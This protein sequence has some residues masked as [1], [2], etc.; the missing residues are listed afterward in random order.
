[1]HLDKI[2]LSKEEL[3]KL[4]NIS[5]YELNIL[6]IG[7]TKFSDTILNDLKNISKINFDEKE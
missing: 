6:L 4:L 5:L 7:K 2:S 3:S 1:M